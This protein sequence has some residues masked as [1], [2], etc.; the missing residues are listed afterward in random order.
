MSEIGNLS[1]NCG[2]QEMVFVGLSAAELIRGW[3]SRWVADQD[4]RETSHSKGELMKVTKSFGLSLAIA[5]Y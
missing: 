1:L 4:Q 2:C 3:R 5:R